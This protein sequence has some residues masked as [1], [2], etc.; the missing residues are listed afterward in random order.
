MG[1]L[2]LINLIIYS[3]M[4]VV[5]LAVGIIIL[6]GKGDRLVKCLNRPGAE[7][8]NVKR[9]RLIN[10]LLMFLA[11]IAF[12]L[13]SVFLSNPKLIQIFGGVLVFLVAVLVVL[14]YTWAKNR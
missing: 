9:V 12:A 13:F 1:N 10:A 6:I 7:R 3:V 8:Y 11:A 14:Q 5:F 4:A 2:D